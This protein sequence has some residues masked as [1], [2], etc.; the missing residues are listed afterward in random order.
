LS[1]EEE[2]ARW[3]V[4]VETEKIAKD[5]CMLDICKNPFADC[6]GTFQAV[7]SKKVLGEM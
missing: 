2:V 5:M 7:Y 4:L 3:L 1:V 6:V